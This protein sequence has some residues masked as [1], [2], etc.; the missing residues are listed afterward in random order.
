MYVIKGGNDKNKPESGTY[1]REELFLSIATWISI[2]FYD[3]VSKIV[4]N[5]YIEEFETKYKNDIALHQS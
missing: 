3:K 5:Y 1:I 4:K 2:E